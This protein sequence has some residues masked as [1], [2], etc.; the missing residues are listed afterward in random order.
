MH[1]ILYYN[2]NWSNRRRVTNNLLQLSGVCATPM[3]V[4]FDNCE[5]FITG[6]IDC[7]KGVDVNEMIICETVTQEDITNILPCMFG[8][9][10]AMPIEF[11]DIRRIL[12]EK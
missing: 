8:R 3:G 11:V 4:K 10:P 2:E 5:I 12:L 9:T 7:I 6:S 1:R